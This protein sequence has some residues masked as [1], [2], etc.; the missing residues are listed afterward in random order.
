[1][2]E[3]DLYFPVKTFLSSL[4][5]EV[6]A[7]VNNC[8]V[9][10]FKRDEGA[11]K[12]TAIVVELKLSF[13]L[14]LLVQGT[15]RQA[16]T[17]NVY[18][19]IAAPNTATKRRNWRTKE[20]GFLKL[21]RQ[22]GLGLLLVKVGSAASDES[23]CVLLDP[24]PYAPRKIQRKQASL[25]REFNARKGDPN[26]GGVNK[27]RIVTAYRQLAIECAQQLAQSGELSPVQ[28][29]ELTQISNAASILQN[30]YYGWFERIRRGVYRLSEPGRCMLRDLASTHSESQSMSAAE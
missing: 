8:D 4:G 25:L 27:T 5:Y 22:L 10:A 7:E 6:K 9:V 15:Q 2:K 24:A 18:L 17:D 3:S 29:K 1:M 19:A 26:I 21:C 23:V 16:L 11:D 30:N 13:S 12:H 20:A 28:L 14:E